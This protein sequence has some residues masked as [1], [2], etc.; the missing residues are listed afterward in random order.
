MPMIVQS[1]IKLIQS[2]M[3]FRTLSYVFILLNICTHSRSLPSTATVYTS[4]SGPRISRTERVLTTPRVLAFCSDT[5][6]AP[7]S[8]HTDTSLRPS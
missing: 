5:S 1:L 6:R 3:Y 7:S 2:S 8:R 4:V